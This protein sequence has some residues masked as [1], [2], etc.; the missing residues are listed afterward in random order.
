MLRIRLRLERRNVSQPLTCFSKYLLI[1][2][3]L[4]FEEFL[5]P[6]SAIFY[7]VECRNP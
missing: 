5:L 1:A 6:H 4:N 7:V 2:I 3:A